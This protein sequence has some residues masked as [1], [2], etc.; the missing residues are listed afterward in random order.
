MISI[1]ASNLDISRYSSKL[2]ASSS[3]GA[4]VTFSGQVRDTSQKGLKLHSLELE[5]Y[6]EMTP[7]IIAH[8]VETARSKWTV[9]DIAVVHRIG[10]MYPGESIVFVGV[11]APHRRDAFASCQYLMDFI[12][13]EATI[14]KR[15]Y[16]YDKSGNIV[17]EWLENKED[18][19]T[20]EKYWQNA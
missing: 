3:N 19:D 1:G 5:H 10:V 11:N 9:D 20:L 13:A 15:E 18:I 6:P 12:K 8:R 14:W 7:H 4:V 17:Y 2:I 16:F